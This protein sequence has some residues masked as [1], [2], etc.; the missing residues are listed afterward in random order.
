MFFNT[1]V[2]YKFLKKDFTEAGYIEDSVTRIALANPGIAIKLINGSRTII[3]TTGTGDLN[4]VIYNIYGK[5]VSEALLPVEYEYED[6]KVKGVVGKPEIARNNRSYQLF[7]V[8]KR[9]I[10][11]KTLSAAGNDC[12]LFQFNH[13]LKLK[14][15]F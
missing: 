3:Q 14:P 4:D 12:C 7:F 8:N 1:P 6:I 10:K 2:R 11:D 9:F 13:V 15:S 5:E